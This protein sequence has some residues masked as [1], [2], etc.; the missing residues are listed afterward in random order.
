MTVKYQTANGTATGGSDFVA[1]PLTTLTF[2]PGQTSQTVNVTVNGDTLHEGNEAFTLK[3]SGP[4]GATLG[5]T[6]GSGTIIDD[7]GV[8]SAYV[9][10]TSV[11]EGNSGTTTAAFTVS[12]SSAPA[13]GQAVSLNYVTANGTATAGSDYVALPTT[14]L[15]FA[16]GQISQ[17]VNVTVNGDTTVE[18]NETFLLNLSTPKGLTIADTGG[19]ATIVNDDGTIVN[20]KPSLYVT[21]VPVLEGDTGTTTASFTLTLSPSS[22]SAVTVNYST[23]NQSAIAGSDYVS[24]PTTSVT[25]APGE[26]SK[27]VGVTVNGDI[28]HEGNETFLLKLAGPVGA[29]LGDTQGQGTIIDNEGAISFAVRDLWALEGNSGT[30]AA[31]FTVTASFAPVS[32]QAV[33]VKYQT[34]DGTAHAPGDYTAVPLTSL[35]FPAGQTSMTV[36]VNVNGDM[37]VEGTETL[38]LNLSGP[39]GGVV[40]DTQA[41]G[42]I[43]DDD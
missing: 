36:T 4:S 6:Q 22:T 19:T 10:D 29:V 8:I 15:T 41:T 21:D 32:G 20:P 27:T 39:A 5:D 3:L 13:V 35:T 12:L 34:A 18:S 43:I 16:A 2:S 25:F 42:S 9:G 31:T 28:A 26:T 7:D 40:G 30:T 17:T 33:S 23:A 1:V 24:V 37:L 38:F 14:T 11:V